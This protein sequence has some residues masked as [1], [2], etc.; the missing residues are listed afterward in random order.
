MLSLQGARWRLFHAIAAM[1]FFGSA[2]SESG[3]SHDVLSAAPM[4]FSAI[5]SAAGHAE[6]HYNRWFSYMTG[7]AV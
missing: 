1:L 3:V 4:L 2:G 6:A 7:T 5:N